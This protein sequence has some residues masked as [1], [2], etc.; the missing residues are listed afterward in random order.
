MQKKIGIQT[1]FYDYILLDMM[2]LNCWAL[3]YSLLQV[4][5]TTLPVCANSSHSSVLE[6][7]CGVI[8]RS[9]YVLPDESIPQSEQGD[10]F[11]LVLL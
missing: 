1:P 11:E 4:A 7:L 6:S 3:E 9:S 8:L 2:V 10:F 5:I